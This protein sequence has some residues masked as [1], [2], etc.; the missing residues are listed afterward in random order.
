MQSA[1]RQPEERRQFERFD[2]DVHVTARVQGCTVEGRTIDMSEGGLCLEGGDLAGLAQGSRVELEMS[3]PGE[4]EPTRLEGRVQWSGRRSER[5]SRCGIEFFG[6]MRGRAVK[7]LAVLVA[8]LAPLAANAAD[9]VPSFDPS[10]DMSLDGYEGGERPDEQIVQTAFEETFAEIDV[11]VEKARKSKRLPGD[12]HLSV[13]LD[14][15]GEKP[16]GVNAELAKPLTK[17]KKLNDCLRGAAAHAHY[18]SYDGPPVVVD[19]E[20]ELDPG[21]ADE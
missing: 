16:L 9:S 7:V 13:L 8:S 15:K 17:N 10:A 1:A 6:G 5:G 18:P 14:P 11:C 21:F 3:V 12:A 2:V 4:A 19:F 20:F